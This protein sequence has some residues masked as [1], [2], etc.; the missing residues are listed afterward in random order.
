MALRH[1][2][3]WDAGFPRR[4]PWFWPL[5]GAAARFAAYAEWPP[6]SAYE[7]AYRELALPLGAAPLAFVEN[8]RKADKREAGRVVLERLY[9]GRVAC[10]G[11]VPTRECDWHDFFNALCFITFP[12]AKHAL[13]A[14]GYRVLRER[15]GEEAARLPG[16]RTPE[17][18]A[19]TLFDEGGAVIAAE[20]DAYRQLLEAPEGDLLRGCVER[21][22]ARV[23]PFGHA[24]FEHLVEGLRCPGGSTRVVR[25]ESARV[26]DAELVRV[27][28]RALAELL[29][30]PTL[31]R[32]PR[33]GG[34]MRLDT[35]GLR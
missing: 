32:Y 30:N 17:Q 2:L 23:V 11:E 25:V 10:A 7:A 27:V 8:V 28:D 9:E 5:S 6:R 1:S 14:R 35:L 12:H 33:E 31:F 13:H 29:A 21:G 19:L 4:S 18:D 22:S 16:A 3:G 34:H 20:A 26:E 15:V 24:L